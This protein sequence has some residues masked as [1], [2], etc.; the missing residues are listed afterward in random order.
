MPFSHDLSPDRA[1]YLLELL[2]TTARTVE[3]QVA[4]LAH[5]EREEKE[6]LDLILSELRQ[7]RRELEPPVPPPPPTTLSRSSA[8][9]F[10]APQ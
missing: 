10:T 4:R 7:I 3:R 5:A 1:R 8:V 2:D 9:Q 6:T